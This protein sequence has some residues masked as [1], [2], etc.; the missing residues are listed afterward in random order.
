MNQNEG[1]FLPISVFP[2]FSKRMSLQNVMKD[3]FEQERDELNAKRG[4]AW[5]D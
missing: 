1:S 2:I 4:I 3:R 5:L